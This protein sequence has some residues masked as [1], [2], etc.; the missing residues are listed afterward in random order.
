MPRKPASPKGKSQ[1]RSRYS[2]DQVRE[3]RRRDREF[4]K[5]STATASVTKCC[6]QSRQRNAD[7]S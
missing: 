3:F 1:G 7:S 5:R 2:D 6:W 4:M